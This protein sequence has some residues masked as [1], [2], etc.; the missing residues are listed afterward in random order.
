M[1]SE[2][3]ALPPTTM[4]QELSVDLGVTGCASCGLIFT[5]PRPSPAVLDRWYAGTTKLPPSRAN[6]SEPY[7]KLISGQ[8][9]ML[10]KYFP[11]GTAATALEV[12]VAE[13][14]F[15]QELSRRGAGKNLWSAL[16]LQNFFRV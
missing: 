11:L 12:G 2:A 8:L 7:R 15:L 13:G 5:N 16:S 9:D 1:K 3:I 14:Y 6:P 10:N 4:D